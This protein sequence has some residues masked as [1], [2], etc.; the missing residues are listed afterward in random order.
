MNPKAKS[1]SK[2]KDY[3]ENINYHLHTKLLFNTHTKILL[4]IFTVNMSLHGLGQ[5]ILSKSKHKTSYFHFGE[6]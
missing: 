2:L 1:I 6:I 3:L 5:L 4:D